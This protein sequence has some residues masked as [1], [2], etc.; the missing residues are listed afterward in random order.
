MSTSDSFG[1]QPPL[2]L[3]RQML[4]IDGL[5]DKTQS[6]LSA[7]KGVSVATACL[8]PL[9]GG[10]RVSHRLTALFTQQWVPQLKRNH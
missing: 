10:D 9:S 8:F 5:Y 7:I 4:S 1:S 6:A 2:E 3:L